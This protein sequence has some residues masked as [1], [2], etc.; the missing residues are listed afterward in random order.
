VQ[1][2]SAPLEKWGYDADLRKVRAPGHRDRT[3]R[4]IV[5]TCF[6]AS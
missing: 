4:R 1:A 6:A 2:P 3:K 5:I